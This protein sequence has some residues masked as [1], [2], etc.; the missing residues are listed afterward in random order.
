M[1]GG[2]MPESSFFPLT[3][4]SFLDVVIADFLD[5]GGGQS[6]KIRVA[7]CLEDLCNC[8]EAM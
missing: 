7:T 4:S 2:K 3:F 6:N 8:A 5:G 1:V